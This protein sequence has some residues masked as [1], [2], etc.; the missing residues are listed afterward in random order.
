MT[1]MTAGDLLAKIEWE[2]SVI[3][4]ISYGITNEEVPEEIASLWLQL[5]KTVPLDEELYDIIYR[6]AKAEEEAGG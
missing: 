6:L 1:R 2:G 3:D 4:A 5:E